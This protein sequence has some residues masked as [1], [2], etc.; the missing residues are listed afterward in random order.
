MS[1]VLLTLLGREGQALRKTIWPTLYYV[2]V[3]NPE[4]MTDD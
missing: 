2:V 1:S 4:A 3:S